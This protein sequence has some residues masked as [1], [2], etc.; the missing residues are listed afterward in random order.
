MGGVLLHGGKLS[1]RKHFPL[2]TSARNR[3]HQEHLVSVLKRV[4]RATEETNVLFVHIDIEEA[5]NLS[6]VVAQMRLQGGKLLIEISE[7]LVQGRRRAGD[8]RRA[9]GMAA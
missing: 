9:A 1:D 8:L 5:A 2:P 4:G 3:R 7:E 6:G